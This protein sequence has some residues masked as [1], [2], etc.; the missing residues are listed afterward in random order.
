MGDRELILR[1]GDREYTAAIDAAGAVSVDG[2]DPIPVRATGGGT[3][4]VGSGSGRQAWVAASGSTRWVFLD[5]EVFEFEAQDSRRPRP[6]A[7]AHAALFAPMP[8]TVVRVDV[9]A[10]ATVRKGDT[11]LILEAM[12]MV[13]PVRAPADGVVRAV[14]CQPR[15]LVKPGVPLVEME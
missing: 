3:V 11:L 2:S 7:A 5:G 9:A 4:R 6:A 10:G 14:L 1:A 15:D 13:L 8:A 12:K